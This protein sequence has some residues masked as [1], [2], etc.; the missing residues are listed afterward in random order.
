M[1][2][3]PNTFLALLFSVVS[4]QT[5]DAL[6][7]RSS[8]T[9]SSQ[10]IARLDPP[11]RD[12]V[13]ALDT[14]VITNS[15]FKEDQRLY[16][17]LDKDNGNP[18]TCSATCTSMGL[19]CQPY[20]HS[21]TD[22][23][24]Q[25]E[26][27][28]LYSELN[29]DNRAWQ[30]Q[31]TVEEDPFIGGTPHPTSYKTPTNPTLRNKLLADGTR[32]MDEALALNI[33]GKGKMTKFSNLIQFQSYKAWTTQS[34]FKF[35]NVPDN[36]FPDTEPHTG[37][38][39]AYFSW[40]QYDTRW[41]PNIIT[42]DTD[43]T[44]VCDEPFL[45]DG[46]S[47]LICKCASSR[48]GSPD[49]S[50]NAKNSMPSKSPYGRR[51]APLGLLKY[52]STKKEKRQTAWTEIL[53]SL[54]VDIVPRTVGD[55]L[56]SGVNLD[57]FKNTVDISETE[58]LEFVRGTDGPTK[59]GQ[60]Y[61]SRSVFSDDF[62]K[63]FSLHISLSQAEA[64]PEIHRKPLLGQ[65]LKCSDE[66]APPNFFNLLDEGA[67][68]FGGLATSELKSDK[69]AQ[70][71][72]RRQF[73]LYL[74]GEE[75][76]FQYNEGQQY[77]MKDW[78]T[79]SKQCTMLMGKQAKDNFDFTKLGYSAFYHHYVSKQTERE[80]LQLNSLG[81]A[82]FGAG[83][84][85]FCKPENCDIHNYTSSKLVQFQYSVNPNTGATEK[86][87]NTPNYFTSI[88]LSGGADDTDPIF[89]QSSVMPAVTWICGNTATDEVTCPIKPE[90]DQ[91]LTP[92]CCVN[93][94]YSDFKT[95]IETNIET[96]PV[97]L[98]LYQTAI[99]DIV[100]QEHMERIGGS[101]QGTVDESFDSYCGTR[102]MTD[103]SY[104]S[105]F[106]S[107]EPY[108]RFN[109]EKLQQTAQGF[110]RGNANATDGSFDAGTSS[111]STEWITDLNFI[112]VSNEQLY[113]NAGWENFAYCN[114][115]ISYYSFYADRL[116]YLLE[117]V[118]AFSNVLDPMTVRLKTGKIS[119]DLFHVDD[120]VI[121]W[122]KSAW[123][124]APRW[125]I[126]A[127]AISSTII[128]HSNSG[129]GL[130]PYLDCDNPD[131]G[132]CTTWKDPAGVSYNMS[133]LVPTFN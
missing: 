3:V 126:S 121:F 87:P 110:R 54:N 1:S 25:K 50:N 62:P 55:K 15:R 133:A 116:L 11:Y 71:R 89:T 115:K 122:T 131:L 95:A 114:G 77:D 117:F 59:D 86:I 37:T 84:S 57:Q 63:Y 33:V 132:Q 21:K 28:L 60:D 4:M 120:Y 23:E 24:F 104:Q 113:E 93:D 125:A 48:A 22:V 119:E 32:R 79:M 29:Y 61:V 73:N 88:S 5:Q 36:G 80:I 8:T 12:L 112:R 118:P 53:D 91:T 68:L 58:T 82:I 85:Q 67:V 70:L 74:A 26:I 40:A 10:H 2:A 92:T 127:C 94:F 16:T 72:R 123:R 30:D 31:N 76:P 27:A 49:P 101:L 42:G 39:S 51:G 52:S 6:N 43:V 35:A 45:H 9:A 124:M 100:L 128:P 108:R 103:T 18:E 14:P 47:S 107:S 65:L 130:L 56:A 19:A 98:G 81:P 69:L 20:S 129:S 17:S 38:K 66:T 7:D 83:K 105:M 90:L 111:T 97:P 109:G 41:G 106:S 44:S 64:L 46:F 78:C 102:S 99:N 13:V 75:S 34:T 96:D